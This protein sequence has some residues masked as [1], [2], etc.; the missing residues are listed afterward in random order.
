M[1]LGAQILVSYLR[2]VVLGIS[3]NGSFMSKKHAFGCISVIHFMQ[4]I[5]RVL[6]LYIEGNKKNKQQPKK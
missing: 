4:Y 5:S 3:L 1:C 2:E 6:Q